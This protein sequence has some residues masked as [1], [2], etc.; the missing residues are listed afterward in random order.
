M[1]LDLEGTYAFVGDVHNA[2]I[3]V[4]NVRQNKTKLSNHVITN[5]IGFLCLSGCEHLKLLKEY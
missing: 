1:F 5:I 2:E 4:M 3:H